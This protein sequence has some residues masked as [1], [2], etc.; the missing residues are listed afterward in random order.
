MP[1]AEKMQEA[2]TARL[3][4]APIEPVMALTEVGL[5][6]GAGTVL[7]E[8]SADRWGR[9]TLAIDDSEERIL[10]LLA[11]AYGQ[12][13]E[14]GVIGHIRRAS[15]QYGRGETCLA[16]IELAHAGLPALT[17]RKRA[18]YRL[19]MADAALD[20]GVAPRDLLKAC[21]V[22]PSVLDPIGKG[23]NVAEPRIPAGNGIESGEWTN[24]YGS[25]I[26]PVAA[27]GGTTP[28][29]YL[30]GDP[31][32]FFDSLYGPVHALAGRL[33]IDETWLLGLAA[34]ESGW[35]D[36]H[37]RELND[38]FGVTH[39]GGPNVRYNTIADAVAYW[40][41]RYGPIVR[42]ATSA[43]DFVQRLYE[44]NYNTATGTWRGRVLNAIQ[45]IPHHLSTWKAKNNI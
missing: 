41:H 6:R 44:A 28:D 30:T 1:S 7:A 17:E 12:S 25:S 33:G 29:E 9:P 2:W 3:R 22:D 4:T 13:V 45:S 27:R 19:F 43:Q 32:K 36:P 21:G 10:A 31:D 14:R 40:E 42:G 35:L 20:E 39:G 15:E 26:T 8:H 5:V 18:A 23:F 11:I 24:D 34:H 16:L 38:P 37:D